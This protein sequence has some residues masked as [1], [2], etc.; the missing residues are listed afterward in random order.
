MKS[1]IKKILDFE[2]AKLKVNK[3]LLKLFLIIFITLFIIVIITFIFHNSFELE[4]VTET[5]KE[6]IL[7][8]YEDDIKKMNELLKSPDIFDSQKQ[9]Y[10]ERIKKLEFYL[11]NNI[12]EHECIEYESNSLFKYSNNISISFMFYILISMYIP[13]ILFS[14]LISIYVFYDVSNGMIKNII[15]SGIDKKNVYKGKLL[16]QFLINLIIIGI[17]L[18]LSLMIGIFKA[19]TNLIIEVQ[20]KYYLV[21]AIGYYFIQ[22]IGLL[23]VLCVCSVFFDMIIIIFKNVIY[24]ISFISFLV[25][26]MFLASLIISKYIDIHSLEKIY[27]TDQ[28]LPFIN[29]KYY[30][31]YLQPHTILIILAYLILLVIIIKLNELFFKRSFT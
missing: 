31:E 11:D 9:M 29:I 10:L 24:V 1:D 6:I 2:K 5:Q 4:T 3:S 19:D 16:L 27:Y 30:F 28:F 14:L 18:I 22:I 12:V 26:L 17:I 8:S 7:A 23:F 13:L 25:F 15:A 20:N 21:N